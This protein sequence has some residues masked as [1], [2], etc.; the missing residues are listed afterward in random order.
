MKAFNILYQDSDLFI[1]DKPANMMVH[2]WRGGPPDEKSLMDF[3][4]EELGIWPHPVNRL[5]RQTSGI[6]L[7][8]HNPKSANFLKERWNSLEVQKRY[9]LLAKGKIEYPGVFD[10][11]LKTEAGI[12]QSAKTSYLPLGLSYLKEIDMDFTFLEVSLSTGR[13]HQIRR[14][15]S[16]HMHNLV[17]DTRYG[18]GIINDAF[19]NLGLRRLFLHSCLLRVPHPKLNQRVEVYSPLPRDLRNILDYLQ[20]DY[21][22]FMS[23]SSESLG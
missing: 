3:I 14:H 17:G 6:V 15:F 2:P 23:S 1:V 7:F 12:R 21:R 5:D 19:R 22:S 16:R 8:A 9:L 20:I 18:K 4:K 13:R 11:S 10:N